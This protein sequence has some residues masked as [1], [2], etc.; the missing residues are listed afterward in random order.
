MY[1]PIVNKL[2]AK[3]QE[4]AAKTLWSSSY[5]NYLRGLEGLWD[6]GGIQAPSSAT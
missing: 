4:T 6:M 3:I 2:F 1:T 5:P